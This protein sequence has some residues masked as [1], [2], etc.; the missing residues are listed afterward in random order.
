MAS[1]TLRIEYCVTLV[2]LLPVFSQGSLW[3]VTS[4]MHVTQ[5]ARICKPMVQ[6]LVQPAT[7]IYFFES[8]TVMIGY[9]SS[10]LFYVHGKYKL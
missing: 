1:L 3:T 9:R 2:W 6:C 7:I 4:M 5:L 8:Q 10:I